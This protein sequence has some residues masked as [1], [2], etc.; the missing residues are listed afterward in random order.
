[1][2]KPKTYFEQVPLEIIKKIVEEQVLTGALAERSQASNKMLF[3]KALRTTQ[4][5]SRASS[6]KSAQKEFSKS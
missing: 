3:E 2:T 1:M 6:R 5:I 4:K